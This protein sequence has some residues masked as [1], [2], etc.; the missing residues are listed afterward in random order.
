MC[1]KNNHL[2]EYN[3]TTIFKNSTNNNTE[4]LEYESFVLQKANKL[5][6]PS[7]KFI[8]FNNNVLEME[9][10]D[11]NNTLETA[12][13]LDRIDLFCLTQNFIL[14]S[15]GNDLLSIE[16][17]INS[18]ESN[19]IK[20]L[21]EVYNSE[22]KTNNFCHGNFSPQNL[23]LKENKFIVIDFENSFRGNPIFDIGMTSATLSTYERVIND[24][25]YLTKL[26]EFHSEYK[27]RMKEKY[28]YSDK[29]F[30]IVFDLFYYVL[31]QKSPVD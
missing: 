13:F 16:N 12:E 22:P 3:G 1:K 27:K 29:N 25:Y 15:N 9:Y 19:S 5:G 7:P 14:N 10:I 4:R 24:R 31:N 28:K 8:S 21:I 18:Q 2:I 17:I 6:I 11:K 26:K 30:E 23:I 20:K